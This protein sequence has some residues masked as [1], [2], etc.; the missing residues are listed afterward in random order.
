MSRHRE[1]PV[2]RDC[3][4]E[5]G[6]VAVIAIAATAY[7]VVYCALF[8]Y[9]RAGEPIRFVLGFPSW[10]FWG[11]VAPWG[12]CV[13]ICGWFSWWFMSD[14]ELGEVHEDAGRWLSRSPPSRA[15]RRPAGGPWPLC[16][17][18]SRRRS[19]WGRSR[20]A[21]PRAA[22]SSKPISWATAGWGPGPWR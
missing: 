12:V 5:A 9:G 16:S 20:R 6:A 13:L 1:G 10:V 14:E 21:R 4:R 22:S 17:A 15:P 2:V 3:R 18:S 11:V 7:S 8:G 19:G